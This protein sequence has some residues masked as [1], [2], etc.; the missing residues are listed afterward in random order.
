MLPWPRALGPPS[1][2]P[3]PGP[4][5]PS[6]CWLLRKLRYGDPP[7]KKK[8]K[9]GDPTD[10]NTTAERD[11]IFLGHPGGSRAA[12]PAH[13]LSAPR[14]APPSLFIEKGRIIKELKEN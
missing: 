10:F 3:S 9:Q 13:P 4:L 11:G 12:S 14:P 5:L 1:T 6:R 8:P 2:R 7:P